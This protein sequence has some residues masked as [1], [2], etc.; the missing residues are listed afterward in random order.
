MC[1]R[2]Q[3]AC[4]FARVTLPF[5]LAPRDMPQ[6]G[7]PIIVAGSEDRLHVRGSLRGFLQAERVRYIEQSTVENTAD[8]MSAPP[9]EDGG[10]I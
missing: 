8:R 2:S 6:A 3:G 9:G 4:R 10:R 5:T 1:A 7:E